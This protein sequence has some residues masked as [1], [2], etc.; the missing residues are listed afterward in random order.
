MS[1]VRKA[2]EAAR[3]AAQHVATLT[4]EQKN[5]YLFDLA[6]ALVSAEGDIL[7]ANA[8]DVERAEAEGLSLPKLKRLSI[9]E[10]SLAQMAEGLRQVAE[11]DDP[12]AQIRQF[13]HAAGPSKVSPV[14]NGLGVQFR[15]IGSNRS[16]QVAR[17]LTTG[18][19]AMRTP[20][21]STD[22]PAVTR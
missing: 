11:L 5:D 14:P 7:R 17:R 13:P 15:R 21:N 3:D 16:Q 6:G 10:E 19:S 20:M 2:A 12:V 8:D 18:T 1:E 22:R 4:A 9:T